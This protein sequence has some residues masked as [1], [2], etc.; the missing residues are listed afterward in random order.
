MKLWII[1]CISGYFVFQSFDGKTCFVN[2]HVCVCV[3]E[4]EGEG[5]REKANTLPYILFGR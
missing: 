5:E 3:G 4:E 1:I 2:V